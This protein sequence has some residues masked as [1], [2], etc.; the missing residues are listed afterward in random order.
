[1]AYTLLLRQSYE[2]STS[3]HV[4]GAI[5]SSN[6]YTKLRELHCSYYRHAGT[7]EQRLVAVRSTKKAFHTH[8][9]R[10]EMLG[11]THGTSYL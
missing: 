3:I 10:L 11:G 8:F 6:S 4:L 7:E 2:V 5:G 1:M 9:N